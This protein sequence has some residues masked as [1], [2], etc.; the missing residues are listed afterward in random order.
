MKRRLA[1][2]HKGERGYTLIE[3]ILGLTLAGLLAT[4][5]TIFSIQTMTVSGTSNNRMQALMQVENAG[6]W[7]TRDVQMSRNVTFGNDAGFPLLLQW[8]D[9]DNNTFAATYSLNNTTLARSLLE[10]GVAAAGTLVAQNVTSASSANATGNS[11]LVRF[12]I[13]CSYGQVAVSRTYDIQPRLEL[14]RA[15]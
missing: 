3:L 1:Y 11:T 9:T 12:A 5:F 13:T 15:P 7:M 10:N 2:F 14:L 6:F 4:G 8:R